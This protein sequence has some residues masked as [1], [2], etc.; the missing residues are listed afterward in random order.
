MTRVPLAEQEAALFYLGPKNP[1]D[2]M[3]PCPPDA[4]REATRQALEE[5]R[6]A[7]DRK[8]ATAAEEEHARY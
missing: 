5:W 6:Q 4:D 8:E 7:K 2:P 1:Q 3:P